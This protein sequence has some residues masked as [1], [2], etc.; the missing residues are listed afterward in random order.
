MVKRIGADLIIYRPKSAAGFVSAYASATVYLPHYVDC[1]VFRSSRLKSN[2]RKKA[3]TI[4]FLGRLVEAK[5]V[6]LLIET[7]PH[8]PTDVNLVMVGKGPLLESLQALAAK[9]HVDGRTTFLP[10]IRHDD[11]PRFMNQLD[12][13]VLPSVDTKYWSEQF[14]RVLIEAMACEVP[15]VASD[16]GGIA[17][18]VGEAGILFRAGS[19]QD[20]TEK[21][22][23]VVSNEFLRSE[24][25]QKGRSRALEMFDV[26]VVAS[27]LAAAIRD[28]IEHNG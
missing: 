7:L 25:A 19:M 28:T 16:S 3:V 8:L 2:A 18:V 15:V 10:P 27:R 4:G 13:L 14:G 9:L 12:V 26:P 23:S 5:G 17:E 1:S 11:V 20:L 21:L 6:Q 24:L 22:S